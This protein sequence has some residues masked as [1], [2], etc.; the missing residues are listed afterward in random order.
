MSINLYPDTVH[1]AQLGEPSYYPEIDDACDEIYKATK[2]FGTDEK[3]IIATLGSKD[4]KERFLIAF[5][6]K[7]KYGKELYDL[8]KKENSG[9]FGILTQLLALPIP[10][11]EAKIIRIAT[12]GFGT[13]EKLLYSVICGRS[14]EEIEI[15]KKAYFQR[16][17]KDLSILVS[18]ELSGD[19]KKLAMCCLQGIEEKYDPTYHTESKAREDAEK[20]YK[21]G[22]GKWGTDEATLFEII[23]KAPPKYL[24]LINDAYVNKYEVNLEYALKKELSGK[25]E[26]AAI[27]HL[28]MKLSPY[29][30]MAEHIKSTCAMMG[31]DELG[32]SCA[33]LRY[34]SVL[35]QVMMEHTAQFGKT[36]QER[37][38]DELLTRRL[39]VSFRGTE[40]EEDDVAVYK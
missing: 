8:M 5:R 24:K 11:A 10:E 12:K 17:N 2:G 34:Q 6:Y 27:F 19:I 33:I 29:K 23:C 31:T 14:N 37:F 1:S 16:Y 18:S 25:A 40:R 9:D 38:R 21:A 35:P 26:S 13:K 36:L 3:A 30:T 4:C 28:N 15:L 7:E 32:L 39:H 22:Q 20:F